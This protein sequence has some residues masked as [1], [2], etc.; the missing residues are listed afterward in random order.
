MIATSASST[1]VSTGHRNALLAAHVA[2]VLFGLTGIL[3]ALI[4]ADASV[5]TFGRATFAFIALGF[6]AGLKGTRLLDALSWRNLPVIG[7]TG[8]L[9]AAHWVTFFIAVKVGGVAVATLG[10]ASFPAFIALVDLLLFRE[11]IGR[12]EGLLL[13]MVTAGLVLVVPSFDLLDKG[14]VGL[15]WGLASGLS[16]ALLAVANRRHTGGMNALQIAFWQN[17]V[18]AALM[19]PFA[20]SH[21]A[22]ASLRADDW[23]NLALLGV[24]CTGLSQFLFVKSLDGLQARTAGM[25]IA[26]EP[27][28]AIACAWWLFGEQPSL[29]MGAGAALVVLATVLSARCK[30]SSH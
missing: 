14:T 27:V 12:T 25:I 20:F 29:R 9:L 26:L 6:A 19:I 16:F 24:F 18:V 21:L 23:V 4:L 22:T 5:I 3:G 28:Y 2:A 30:P 10:F 7:L 1:G 17:V 13:L 15:V 11:R 8:T